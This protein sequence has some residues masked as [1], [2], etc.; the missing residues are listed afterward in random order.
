MDRD[1]I[2]HR[3]SNG[4]KRG[5]PLAHICIDWMVWF[6]NFFSLTSQRFWITFVGKPTPDQLG[7]LV[8]TDWRILRLNGVLSG[9]RFSNLF[10][11]SNR[12]RPKKKKGNVRGKGARRAD[13]LKIF[14]IQ[15]SELQAMW[16]HCSL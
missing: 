14:T 1:C 9:H 11:Q 16:I 12:E 2:G 10:H 6:T 15:H 5:Q 13:E 4:D 7:M 8:L 3:R